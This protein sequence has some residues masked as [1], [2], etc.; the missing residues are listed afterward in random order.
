MTIIIIIFQFS[1]STTLDKLYILIAAACA[2]ICG[3]GQPYM[4]IIFG[5]VTGSIISYASQLNDTLTEEQKHVLDEVLWVDVKSFAINTVI[6]SV[7]TI[8]CTYVSTVLFSYSAINQVII[9]ISSRDNLLAIFN[10]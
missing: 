7:V 6:I 10:R 9:I 1:F 4:L 5:D 2:I 3:I 8:I